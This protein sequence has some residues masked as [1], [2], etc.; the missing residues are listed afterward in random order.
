M[1]YRSTFTK[2]ATKVESREVTYSFWW[3]CERRMSAK[4]DVELTFTIAPMENSFN[5]KY[6]DNGDR[7]HDGVNGS[8]T[9]NHPWAI[10]WHY[11]I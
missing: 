9:R 4:P 10:D 11:D 5:V 7:Y 2:L 3:K 6:L 1:L 8:R